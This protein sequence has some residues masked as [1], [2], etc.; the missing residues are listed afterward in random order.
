MTTRAKKPLKTAKELWRDTHPDMLPPESKREDVTVILPALEE[1]KSLQELLPKL[2][3]HYKVCTRDDKGLANAVM[4]GVVT[5]ATPIVVVMDADGTHSAW[6]VHQMVRLLDNDEC[7]LVCGV[8]NAWGPGLKGVLSSE[9]NKLIKA[10]LGIPVNDCTSG[11]FAAR[12]SKLLKL[13]PSTWKGYG[14]Y[15]MALLAHAHKDNWNIECVSTDYQPRIAGKGHTSLMKHSLMYLR[16]LFRVEREIYP[17]MKL[18]GRK[19]K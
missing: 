3:S 15:Y 11:F 6:T 16:R 13:P 12:R 2:E 14:D 7:D 8:R 17:G 5:S 18:R 10:R 1:D 19:A 4:M 9:G